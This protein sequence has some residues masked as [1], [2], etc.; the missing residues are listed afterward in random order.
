MPVAGT[1]SPCCTASLY[2]ELWTCLWKSHAE[3]IHDTGQITTVI[4]T[5][6]P[7]YV[8]QQPLKTRPLKG[9]L[10]PWNP[11]NSGLHLLIQVAF[12]L[13]VSKI[14]P[15]ERET[16][17]VFILLLKVSRPSNHTGWNWI[18]KICLLTSFVESLIFQRL[19]CLLCTSG[20]ARKS[21]YTVDVRRG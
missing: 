5:E 21:G 7:S 6:Q 9:R 10:M 2:R 3:A 17:A 15:L 8:W 18:W 12:H 19:L 1:V 16:H 13:P 4:V 20:L 11:F 14:Q